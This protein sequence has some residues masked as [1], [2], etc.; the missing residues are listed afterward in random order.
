MSYNNLGCRIFNETL[1]VFKK[2]CNK[3]N[4]EDAAIIAILLLWYLHAIVVER[5]LIYLILFSFHGT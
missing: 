1:R 2:P 4:E 5:I 3:L